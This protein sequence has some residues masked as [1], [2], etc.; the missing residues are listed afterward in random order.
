[1]RLMSAMAIAALL[2]GCGGGNLHHES[3][4]YSDAPAPPPIRNPYFDPYASPGQAPA[5]WVP[6]VFNRNGTIVQL[7]DPSQYWDHEDYSHAP[8]LGRGQEAAPEGTY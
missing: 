8:W 2:S 7:K 5:T 4:D 6:P 1:M 3:R